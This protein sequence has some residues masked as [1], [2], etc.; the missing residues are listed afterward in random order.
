MDRK[1]PVT[2]LLEGVKPEVMEEQEFE[3]SE[4]SKL[5]SF[6]GLFGL[7]EFLRHDQDPRFFS[8]AAF[9]NNR[10]ND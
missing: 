9:L 5:L 2:T 3:N 10:V 6:F 1:L 7:I 4:I 8:R